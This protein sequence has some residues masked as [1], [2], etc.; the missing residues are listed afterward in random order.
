VRR[1]AAA[2]SILGAPVDDGTVNAETTIEDDS[3][4]DADNRHNVDRMIRP[5]NSGGD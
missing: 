4:Q 5:Y 3:K 1:V 2:V